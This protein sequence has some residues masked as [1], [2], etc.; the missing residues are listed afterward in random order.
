MLLILGS[1]PE[2]FDFLWCF[3]GRQK[4]EKVTYIPR[5]LVKSKILKCSLIKAFIQ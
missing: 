1:A 5:I 3:L 2:M 4:T